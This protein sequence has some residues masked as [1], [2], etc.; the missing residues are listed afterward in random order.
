MEYDILDSLEMTET[1]ETLFVNLIIII[2]LDRPAGN[3]SDGS[4]PTIFLQH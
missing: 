4:V 2:A 3:T 1:A